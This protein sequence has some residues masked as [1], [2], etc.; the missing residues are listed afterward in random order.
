M[1]VAVHQRTDVVCAEAAVDEAR[2][3]HQSAV[4]LINSPKIFSSSLK[5]RQSDPTCKKLTRQQKPRR[6]FYSGSDQSKPG[7]ALPIVHQSVLIRL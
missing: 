3:C 7:H 5:V 1:F 6:R 2:L 4:C